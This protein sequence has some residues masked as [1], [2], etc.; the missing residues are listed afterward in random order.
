MMKSSDSISL[1]FVSQAKKGVSRT[2]FQSLLLKFILLSPILLISFNVYAN[3]DRFYYFEMQSIRVRYEKELIDE[4][5]DSIFSTIDRQSSSDYER[6][7]IDGRGWLY[8]PALVIFDFELKPEF[9]QQFFETRHSTATESVTQKSNLTSLGYLIDATFLQVKPYSFK[10]FADKGFSRSTNSLAE[11]S[12]NY[13]STYRASMDLNKISFPTRIKIERLENTNEIFYT[14][15]NRQLSFQVDS[16]KK[17]SQGKTDAEILFLKSSKGIENQ[18]FDT[19]SLSFFVTNTHQFNKDIDLLSAVR[20]YDNKSDPFDVITSSY[21][22]NLTV[23]HTD[24]FSTYYNANI[25]TRKDNTFSSTS[26]TGSLGFNHQLYDNLKTSVDFSINKDNFTGGTSSF[27]RSGVN[28]GYTRRIPWGNIALHYGKKNIKEDNQTTN[29]ISKV[30]G[31][32]ITLSSNT[33]ISLLDR[34]QIDTSSI[35]VYNADRSIL[36]IEGIDYNITSIG[37]NL[38]I[39]RGLFGSIDDN[40]QILV[41]Y[42]FSSNTSYDI[43]TPSNSRGISLNL[44]N[45]LNLY[46]DYNTSQSVL[47]SGISDAD[48][49]KNTLTTIGSRLNWDWSTT[50]IEYQDNDS[51]THIKTL[52]LTQN[53][54]FH[55]N[56]RLSLGFGL[57]YT[58][59]EIIDTNENIIGKGLSGQLDWK[60]NRNINLELNYAYLDNNSLQRHSKNNEI[61]AQLVG[62]YGEWNFDATYTYIDNIDNSSILT[63]FTMVDISK[64]QISRNSFLL[65]IER[66]FK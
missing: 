38:A 50:Y 44:W 36:Y 3:R 11:D 17:T 13:Y 60:L 31:E 59:N 5:R 23:K 46:Y 14:T 4:F 40:Q 21:I 57:D 49:T 58:E 43:E 62:K 65:S 30:I 33:G 66:I 6:F 18:T 26:M 20:Y 9:N 34:T 61:S 55:I 45:K 25:Y 52:T 2:A 35:R 16:Y 22:S 27:I 28:F 10:L 37:N 12:N 41:D 42:Q 15:T 64:Q 47:I 56:Y 19:D 1:P 24:N 32:S 54:I 48:F 7:E 51:I 39:E 53:A 8:H 63:N 29:I